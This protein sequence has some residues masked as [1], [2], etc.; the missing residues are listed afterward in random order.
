MRRH[1]IAASSLWCLAGLAAFPPALWALELGLPLACRPGED[2]WPVRLV[3]HDPGPGFA[4]HRCGGVGADGHDGVDL[5]IRNP[6]RMAEGVPVLAGAAGTVRGARDGM[7]DQPPDGQLAHDYGDRQ[8]G[9]GVV[10]DHGEGW[11]TQ[12]CH[13]RQGSLA[14]RTGDRVEAGGRL[15]LVGMSGEANFPHVHL[16]VRRGEAVVDPFTGAPA[17][18]RC[19]ADGGQETAAAPLWRAGLLPALAYRPVVVAAVGLTDRV[20]E[21]GEIVSGVVE[22]GQPRSGSPA[23]VA[24]VLAYQLRRGDR[25]VLKITGPAGEP[26]AEL[27]IEIDQDAPRATRSGGRRTPEGGWPAGTYRVEAVVERGGERWTTTGRPVEIIP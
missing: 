23:L 25:V 10:L 21:H 8:C 4:D 17:A 20:P 27:P 3:D 1:Q 15:G 11:T 7:P 19:A 2:C 9:N 22:D 12:Y 14:V 6:R 24:Y 5:A 16:T 13:L 26:V 18:E